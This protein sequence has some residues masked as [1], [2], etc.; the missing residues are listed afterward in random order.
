MSPIEPIPLVP[1]ALKDAVDEGRLVVFVGAGVSRLLG[2]CGWDELARSLVKACHEAGYI[3]FKEFETLTRESDH[4][5]SISICF[6]IMAEDNKNPSLFYR[7]LKRALKPNKKLAKRYPVYEELWKLGAIFV[8]TNADELFD[9]LFIGPASICS[10]DAF[11]TE[12]FDRTKL[13]HLHGKATEPQS[14]VFTVDQYIKR[15]RSPRIRAFLETLFK[16]YTI[17]FVGYGLA[18]LQLLEYLVLSNNKETNEVRHYFLMPMFRG[19]EHLLEFQ[20]DYYKK[21]GIEVIAYD[22]TENGHNQLYEVVKKWQSEIKL[23]THAQADTFAFIERASS[24]YDSDTAAQVLQLIKNDPPLADHFFK[25][26]SDPRWLTT[27]RDAGYFDPAGNPPPQEAR[28]NPGMFTLPSWSALRYLE[29]VASRISPDDHETFGTLMRVVR[30]IVDYTND[31]GRRIENYRTDWAITRIYS[32]VPAAFLE[33][34]DVD[35]IHKFIES[36]WRTPV[37]SEV[38]ISFLPHLLK[39]GNKELS[40]KLFS[41]ML[42]YHWETRAGS[43]EAVPFVDEFWLGET[44]QKQS[45]AIGKLMPVEAARTVMGIMQ[46]IIAHD[47]TAFHYVSFPSVEDVGKD[48]HPDQFEGILI[49]CLRDV[50]LAEQQDVSVVRDLLTSDH[51]IFRKLSLHAIGKK[52]GVLNGEFWKI[53]SPDLLVDPFVL[54]ELRALARQNFIHFT[55]EQKNKW[56][57]WIESAPYLTPDELAEGVEKHDKYVALQKLRHLS[58]IRGKGHVF[59][60][61]LFA[62]YAEIFGEEVVEEPEGVVTGWIPIESET[63]QLIDRLAMMSV[64]EIFQILNQPSQEQHLWERAATDEALQRVVEA[65]PEKFAV[66]LATF[67]SE[68]QGHLGTIIRGLAQAWKAGKT[69]NWQPLLS[70]INDLVVGE[71]FWSSEPEPRLLRE[72]AELIIVGTQND[73]H[74]FPGE[75][76]PQAESILLQLLAHTPS[77]VGD[78]DDVTSGTLNSPRGRVMF[79]ILNYSL[80]VARLRAGQPASERWASPIRDEFTTRLDKAK[81]DSL[82][83]SVC[84]GEYLIYLYS[85]DKEW[86]VRNIDLIFPKNNERHWR[87]AFSG[88][89]AHATVY[90]EF[91]DMLR[92]RNHYEKAMGANIRPDALRRRVVDHICFAY[93]RNAEKLDDPSSMIRKLVDPWNLETINDIVM[94]FWV[95]RK[96]DRSSNMAKA[97]AVWQ[98]I[99]AHYEQKP[100]LSMEEKK[101]LSHLARLSLYLDSIDMDTLKILRLTAKYADR[102]HET[103]VLVENLDRLADNSPHNV[104]E[105]FLEMLNN[106]IYPDYEVA[107]ITSAVEKI[108]QAGEHDI[109]NSICNM[110]LQR[111]HEFL[112]EVFDRYN[113]NAE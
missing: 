14:L 96:D 102:N 50:L 78:V 80:R 97:M 82:E 77:S 108:Y 57:E 26:V 42:S 43:E 12:W 32:A 7:H 111:G 19:E 55:E 10:A 4:R 53:A 85:L 101:M 29:R 70:T 63:Q 104:G 71:A 105:V 98:R 20:R 65:D 99:A 61:E 30:N 39:S 48:R 86:V 46:E 84:L 17:L 56:V 88:Y 112:R 92:Q 51:P 47:S 89:L 25:H 45:E 81:D 60:D 16:D 15:Y 38:G 109:G 34:S 35:R 23:T 9:K 90:N 68:S 106:D 103:P 40:L 54:T 91:Y 22:I 24:G 59:A 110:Y 8:T 1:Q 18:E 69:F 11:P 5:K 58:A 75:L 36:Q 33:P 74:S 94:F 3:S 2:C 87:A 73:Q 41:V 95:Q 79:A 93:L 67:A 28:D 6:H 62:K 27:L 100:D 113:K 21:F 76:L 64:E 31:T 66:S 83:F 72:V 52:W 37:D 13:Y 49:A 107:H 44:L